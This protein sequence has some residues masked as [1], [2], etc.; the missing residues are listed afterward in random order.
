MSKRFP[1]VTYR[2]MAKVAHKLGF[3]LYRRTK[4]SHEIWRRDK[5]HR[6]TTLPNH[7]S[8]V[9]KRKTLKSILNDLQ[10][11]LEDLRKLL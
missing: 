10:I 7:D 9:L 6:Y 8:H 3:Y 4:G 1:A 2:N 5:D 11:T